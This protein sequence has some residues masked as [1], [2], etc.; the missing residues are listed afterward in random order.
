MLFLLV[1]LHGPRDVT[2][3]QPWKGGR[4][5]TSASS[6][7]KLTGGEPAMGCLALKA[8]LLLQVNGRFSRWQDGITSFY[9]TVPPGI[10]IDP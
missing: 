7:G 2:V 5:I 3:V 9:F 8:V 6:E 10:P 1:G 4:S